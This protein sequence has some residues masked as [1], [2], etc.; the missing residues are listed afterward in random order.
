MHK[1]LCSGEIFFP[2]IVQKCVS[3]CRFKG[4]TAKKKFKRQNIAGEVRN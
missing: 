4:S 1:I 2:A 3:H